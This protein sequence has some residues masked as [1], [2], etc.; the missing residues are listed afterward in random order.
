MGRQSIPGKNVNIFL[1][2][3]RNNQD[4]LDLVMKRS[5][6][7]LRKIIAIQSPFYKA[8]EGTGKTSQEMSGAPGDT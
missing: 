7:I 2:H 5:V 3:F 4:L 1:T 6:F 8:S